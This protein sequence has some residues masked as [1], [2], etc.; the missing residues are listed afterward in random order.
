M[1]NELRKTFNISYFITFKTLLIRQ[2]LMPLNINLNYWVGLVI[3]KVIVCHE[4][5]LQR[6]ITKPHQLMNGRN[7]RLGMN[8]AEDF[9]CRQKICVLCHVYLSINEYLV[10]LQ[11][12]PILYTEQRFAFAC[13]LLLCLLL[14][15]IQKD[16]NIYL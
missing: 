5:S 11:A 12:D 6:R 4:T 3:L 13:K 2:T 8:K 14:S 15:A 1:R 9:L 16:K 7:Y 10:S